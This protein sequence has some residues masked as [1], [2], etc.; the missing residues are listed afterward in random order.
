[1]LDLA[2]L[3]DTLDIVN[4]ILAAWFVSIVAA[5]YIAHESARLPVK[6]IVWCV[7]TGR[8]AIIVLLVSV[9]R[10]TY[11]TPSHRR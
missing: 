1:M 4:F 11:G 5:G 9:R 10:N 8:L 7:L 2:P 6:W 3:E